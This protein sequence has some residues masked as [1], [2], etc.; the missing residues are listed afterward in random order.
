[1]SEATGGG[2]SSGGN[3]VERQVQGKNEKK[4]QLG[5]RKKKEAVRFP[6]PRTFV[7]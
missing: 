7:V 6:N 4:N 2:Q 3:C 1:V 5:K